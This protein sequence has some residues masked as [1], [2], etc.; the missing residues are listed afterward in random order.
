MSAGHWPCRASIAL[1]VGI[2]LLLLWMIHDGLTVRALMA[3]Y[4]LEAVRD[5]QAA[6]WAATGR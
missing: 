6:G 5:W 2:E 3:L 4:P 1:F